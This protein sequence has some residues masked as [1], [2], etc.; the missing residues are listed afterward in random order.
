MLAAAAFPALFLTLVA[1]VLFMTV[2]TS[3][4]HLKHIYL[5]QIFEKEHLLNVN[6]GVFGWCD[7]GLIAR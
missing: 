1:F 7:E 6:M 3:A 5:L 2:S 4:P